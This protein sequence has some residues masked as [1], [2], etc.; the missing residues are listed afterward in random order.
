MGLTEKILLGLSA[1]ERAVRAVLRK[2]NLGSFEFRLAFDAVPR[3]WFAYGM[4]QA[5]SLASSLNLKR[6]TAIEFGVAGGDGLVVME[7]LAA[8]IEKVIPIKFELYGFDTSEGLPRHEDYRD[9]P[10]VWR[11]GLYRMDVE[12]VRSKLKRSDLIFGDVCETIPQFLTEKT[13][14]PIGFISFDLDYYSSTRS[15]FSI[16]EA[17][18]SVIL[19]R[20]VCYF[21][22][23]VGS[24]EQLHCEDVGELLAIREF[25]ESSE[26]TKIRQIMGL[27]SKRA[28]G[29]MWC[30][31]MY[32]FHCFTHPQYNTYI[33]R[34]RE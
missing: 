30:V 19:P 4:Y 13:P 11:Q 7:G 33:G 26:E 14:A 20:V 3:P 22:D 32:A 23:V 2:L 24:D 28:V 25:N 16:F 1:P 34:P 12:T 6:V 5:A 17:P 15:A 29:C 21:D 8:E 31:K 27:S 9:L 18:H 10:Y